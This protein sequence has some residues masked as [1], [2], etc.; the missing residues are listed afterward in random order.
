MRDAALLPQQLHWLL[1]A[2]SAQTAMFTL[3]AATIPLTQRF[4][5]LLYMGGVDSGATSVSAMRW[6]TACEVYKIVQDSL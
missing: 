6:D 5:S 1:R 2:V 3:K 4:C